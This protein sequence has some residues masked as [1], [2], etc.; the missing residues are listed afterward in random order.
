MNWF[1]CRKAT[2]APDKELLRSADALTKQKQDLYW[3]ALMITGDAES[4]EHSIVDAG[5]LVET[6]SYAFRDWLVRWGRSATARVAVNTVR[7]CI[8]DTAA[9]YCNWT[10]S[11]GTHIPLSPAEITNLRELDP[12]EVIQRLDILARSVLVLYGCQRASV[13]EC[14]LLLNVPRQHILTAYCRALQWYRKFAAPVAEITR[15]HSSGLFL[16]RYDSDGVPV[17]HNQSSTI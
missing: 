3:T 14:A 4:A 10:C 11:H 5:G 7:S 8:H 12:N 9:R 2:K 15:P 6:A 17:W 16:V 13:S 1:T